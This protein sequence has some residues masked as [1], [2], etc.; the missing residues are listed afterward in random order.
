VEVFGR[1]LKEFE[2]HGVDPAP[3]VIIGGYGQMTLNSRRRRAG[4][5]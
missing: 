2:H 3:E 5:M 1:P 4:L